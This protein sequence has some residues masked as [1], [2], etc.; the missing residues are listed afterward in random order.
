MLQVVTFFVA[1]HYT[2]NRLSEAA[3]ET[4]KNTSDITAIQRELCEIKHHVKMDSKECSIYK[5][6]DETE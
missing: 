2:M 1:T 4:T 3:V 6:T 5:P